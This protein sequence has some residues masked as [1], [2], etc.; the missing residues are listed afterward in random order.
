ME[1]IEE[2]LNHKE[3]AIIIYQK[4]FDIFLHDDLFIETAIKCHLLVRHLQPLRQNPVSYQQPDTGTSP[5]N[6]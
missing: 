1:K 3:I 4:T 2:S 5:A 6:A